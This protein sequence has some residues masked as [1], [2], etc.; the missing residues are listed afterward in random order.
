MEGVKDFPRLDLGSD[1]GLEE[2]MEVVAFGYPFGA[3]LGKSASTLVPSPHCGMTR[4]ANCNAFNLPGAQPGQLA[5]GAGQLRQG[6]RCGR[7]RL[8]RLQRDPSRGIPTH[9]APTGV[10]FA[11]PVSI[12]SRFVARPEVQFDLPGQADALHKPVTFEARVTL[13]L[14]SAPPLSVELILKAGDGPERKARMDD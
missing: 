4:M 5:S 8:G 11:I 6:N 7:L 12:V 14:P 2:L 1:G 10:N 3:T 9:G 13:L